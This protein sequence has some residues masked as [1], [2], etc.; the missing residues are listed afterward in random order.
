MA[1]K[2]HPQAQRL[3]TMIVTVPIIGATAY[4]LYERLVHGKPQRTLP[5]RHSAEP[6]R[7]HED[8]PGGSTEKA[9]TNGDS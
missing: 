6:S 9:G 5:P 1:Q 3:R 2:L 8:T 4:V 7:Q